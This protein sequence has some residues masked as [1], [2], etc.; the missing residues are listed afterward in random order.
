M[1]ILNLDKTIAAILE[2][3]VRLSDYEKRKIVFWYDNEKT[4]GEEDLA[5]IKE[6]LHKNGI[7]MHILDDNFYETKR[8]LEHQD[9]ESNYLIYSPYPA[10]PFEENWL[11]DIQLYSEKFE[12]SRIS[13][14]K[15]EIGIEGYELDKFLQK[16]QKFFA[17]K[18][19]VTNFK[20]F[21]QES[22]KEDDLI[23]GLFAVLTDSSDTAEREIVKNLLLASLFEDENTIWEEVIRYDLADPFWDIVDRTFGFKIDHPTLKKLFISFL[24]THINRNAKISLGPLESYVNRKRQSNEC[25]IFIK[26]WMDNSKDSGRFDEY[27][28]IIL[29]EEDN[30]IEKAL[31]SS[32]IKEKVECSLD[33]EA[34][35]IFDKNIIR[36]IVSTLVEDG[37]DYEKYLSW[38]EARKT[39]HYYPDFKDIYS[40][41]EYAI[42]LI[43][44]SEEIEETKTP[45]NSPK[46]HFEKYTEKYYLHDLYYRKFYF[47]YDKDSEKV[48]LKNGIRERV[49]RE[50]RRANEKILIKW[51]E[52]LH[53]H[54]KEKWGIELIDDQKDFFKNYISKIIKRNDR[55]KVVVI[56]SDA[57]RYEV[58]TELKDVLH[59][60]PKGTIEIN[61]MVG[62]LPSY[63]KLGMASLLPHKQLEYR[64]EQIL[65]DGIDSDGIINREKI[66]VKSQN[67][68]VA[69]NFTDLLDLN[70]D[71]AREKIKGKRVVYIYHNRIDNTA[72]GSSL[73]RDV[74]Q[75]ADMTINDINKMVRHL[76]NSLNVSNIIIT[77]DHGFIYNRDSLESVDKIET[78]GFDKDKALILNKRFIISSEKKEFLN[79]H[80]FELSIPSDSEEQQ[81]IYTP[82]AD[83]RFKLQGK[84]I[85]YVHGGLSL[86]EIV[87]P[88]LSYNHNKSL[89]DLERKG[90]EY[91]KVGITTIGQSRK[92][93]NNPF[94][95]KL[96]Q[97]E[98]VTDKREPLR[99]KIALYNNN[100]ER[101]S[102]E[103]MIIADKTSDEPNERILETTLTISSDLKNGIYTLK[104]VDEDTKL[105]LRDVLDVDVEVDILISDDF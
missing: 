71:D 64:K 36:K 70:L 56:I 75:A 94:K 92:I 95:I 76:V 14:I 77:A 93:T 27:C 25:E 45:S 43:R 60:I 72:D 3:Y 80:R 54:P 39:K 90:I 49:E 13:D 21:Y 103:K 51:S 5:S 59:A 50:Y 67:E 68:S 26:G 20:K 85:N 16:H 1:P 19:R 44:L 97:T 58:A 81:Y 48:I 53:S 100:G 38:I 42:K 86:Q 9:T 83:L 102:D 88:V 35:D 28:K 74:F 40:A 31:T 18:K 104:A 23:K 82:Y 65:V 62:C 84:G 10:R 73:E 41:L 61:H 89:S 99:C 46:E 52:L 30:K 4:A 57:L 8:I 101:V 33:A 32:L 55:D 98:N 22:W 79:T 66:L 37:K 11:L 91:G 2:K 7:K 63:T 15:I 24:M 12:N 96:L 47:H 69:F 34:P 78:T 87:I 6:A 29:L 17:K 105:T